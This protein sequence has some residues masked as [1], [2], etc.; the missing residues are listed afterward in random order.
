[1][2]HVEPILNA[3]PQRARMDNVQGFTAA[4]VACL[5]CAFVCN[6]CA[7]A[8]IAEDKVKTLQRCIRLD[9]DCAAICATTAGLLSRAYDADAST[10]RAQLQACLAACVACA[11][12]CERHAGQ[13]EHCRICAETC[14]TCERACQQVMGRLPAM[15]LA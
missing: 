15:A 3:H 8:C 4:I 13:H 7:D 14:R 9:L 11:E 2:K 6:S 10:L 1:M 5:D 12:E